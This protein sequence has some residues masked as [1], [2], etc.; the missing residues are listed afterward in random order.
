MFFQAEDVNKTKGLVFFKEK[1]VANMLIQRLYCT[2]G[3]IIDA[4]FNADTKTFLFKNLKGEVVGE[5]DA[6]SYQEIIPYCEI[7]E[8]EEFA[9]DNGE[10]YRVVEVETIEAIYD[11]QTQMLPIRLW[12]ENR[13]LYSVG[14]LNNSERDVLIL[15]G[16]DVVSVIDG[17]TLQEISPS[18][19]GEDVEDLVL[20]NGERTKVIEVIQV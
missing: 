2:K 14:I 15:H 3:T 1:W 8:C 18:Y 10:I 16:S 4:E 13:K 7:N 19:E 6:V 9:L 20:S 11:P 5:I 12:C 17:Y